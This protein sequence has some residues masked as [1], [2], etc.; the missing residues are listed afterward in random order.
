M[1][2]R[3]AWADAYLA[4]LRR[5]PI[6]SARPPIS[7]YMWNLGVRPR[8]AISKSGCHTPEEIAEYGIEGFCQLKNI[9]ITT[10]YEIN[11]WLLNNYGMK[12]RGA[13]D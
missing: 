7:D 1:N 12:L 5:G 11:E 10:A 2:D 4:W 9:G 13:H 6:P 8:K 3:D